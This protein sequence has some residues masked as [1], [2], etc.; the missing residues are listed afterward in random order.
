MSLRN[1]RGICTYCGKNHGDDNHICNDDD[2]RL[3]EIDREC[4]PRSVREALI[5]IGQKGFNN[6]VE[7]LE[8]E[9]KA[10]RARKV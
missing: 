4:G 8:N 1:T 2:V 3:L 9:A 10:I 7:T 6:K 5:S